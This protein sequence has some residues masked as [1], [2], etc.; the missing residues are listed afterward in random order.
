MDE[1]TKEGPMYEEPIDIEE[2]E[3]EPREE[4]KQGG[5]DWAG[6]LDDGDDSGNF[7]YDDGGDGDGG[8]GGDGNGDDGGDG[9]GDGGDGGNDGDD[10]HDALLAQGW[11]AEIHYNLEGNAYYHPKLLSLV[12]L[13]HTRRTVEY[14]TGHWTYPNYTGF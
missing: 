10:D 7:D 5:Q 4:A 12:R 6:D 11:T 8:D 13:Y 2:S 3:E 9:D 14:R 1:E